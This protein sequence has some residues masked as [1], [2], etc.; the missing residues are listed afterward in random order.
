MS[1]YSLKP[2][3]SV[4][5]D[6]GSVAINTL[7]RQKFQQAFN[8]DDAIAGAVDQMQAA[9]FEGDQALKMQNDL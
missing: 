6:P 9:D 2:Y 5:R 1:R 7:Q 3:V 4:Y 8:A